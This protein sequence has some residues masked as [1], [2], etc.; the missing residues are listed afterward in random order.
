M[1]IVRPIS[2]PLLAAGG[3][4]VGWLLFHW[5][6]PEPGAAA[7]P[8]GPASAESATVPLAAAP[9]PAPTVVVVPITV[10]AAAP[11]PSS[12][13]P[14]P[15]QAVTEVHR[16]AVPMT[17]YELVIAQDGSIVVVGDD[18]T[19]T[20]NTGDTASSGAV[21][22]DSQGSAVTSGASTTSAPG[23]GTVGDP[24]A[25][26]ATTA[27]GENTSIP[28]VD[29]TVAALGNALALQLTGRPVALAGYEDHSVSVFGNDQIVTYD[30][31]N[32]FLNRNGQINANT[33]DTDS[34]GLNAV[35]VV[36]SVVRSGDHVEDGDEDGGDNGD[37]GDNG[38]A[39]EPEEPEEQSAAT[40]ASGATTVAAGGAAASDTA[41][42]NDPD[43]SSSATGRNPLV[44][45]AD[46]YD[47]VSVRATGDRN[48]VTYDDSNVVIGGTGK[49]NAQIG[50]GDTSGAV[51]MGIRGSDVRSGSST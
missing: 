19:L 39:E 2:G 38:D 37:N 7:S 47:D 18:A 26:M 44:I 28:P 11:P 43:A 48:I 21:V 32:V 45:G 25:G 13:H 34:S 50:D 40:G 17:Q 42:S 5:L 35:D 46:G 12:P 9:P 30:D 23:P 4:V 24:F 29:P 16:V 22:L 33:G 20:A 1:S 15:S 49:V 6:S 10:P 36:D 14:S 41:T 51:V 31:S 3:V 27:A 8:A